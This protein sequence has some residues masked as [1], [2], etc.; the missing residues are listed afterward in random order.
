MAILSAQDVANY[1]LAKVDEVHWE[2]GED[3]MEKDAITTQAKMFLAFKR[4]QK[5]YDIDIFANKCM[6]E[7]SAIP[8]GYGYCAW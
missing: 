2:A 8:Y 1:F 3:K 6:P 5:I 4:L 7:M